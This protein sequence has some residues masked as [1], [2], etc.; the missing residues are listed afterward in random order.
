MATGSFGMDHR[1]IV[2]CH[3]LLEKVRQL[4]WELTRAEG[5]NLEERSM[6]VREVFG[7]ESYEKDVQALE[8]R[9]TVRHIF[10]FVV[11]R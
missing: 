1:A 6:K 10:G 2:W 11:G 8:A 9:V 4:V 3:G 7:P 5:S